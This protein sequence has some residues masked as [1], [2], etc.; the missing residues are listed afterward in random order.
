[1]RRVIF[2]FLTTTLFF[3]GLT[4]LLRAQAIVK[5]EVVDTDTGQPLQGAHVFLSGT[6]LG[7]YSDRSGQYTL[8]RIPIGSFR[9]IVTMIGY[10]RM[11]YNVDVEPGDQLTIDLNLKP[12][13][14]EMDEI[15]VDDLGKKWRRN[16][17]RFEELFLGMSE[18]ADSVFILNPD[19]LRFDT[20]FWGRLKAEALAPLEIVNKSLGYEITYYLFEFKHTGH[21]TYWDGEPLFKEMTPSDPTQKFLWEFNRLK[22]FHGSMRHFWLS[23]LEDRVEEEGFHMYRVWEPMFPGDTNNLFKVTAEDIVRPAEKEYLKEVR[24]SGSL[25]IV[26][27]REEEDWRY[28]EWTNERNRGPGW[29]QVS[30]LELNERSITVD[31]SGEVVEPYGA[32]QQGYL[33]FHRLADLTPREYRPDGYFKATNR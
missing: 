17:A 24:F 2:I 18:N 8:R 22:A 31:P 5:G 15:N 3:F 1:M 6:K 29:S 14:Y 9:I 23:V 12:V 16:L 10:E 21:T 26:Y 32:I 11:V 13:V 27:M 28:L 4:D 19:V 33:G 20:N 30:W 7:T 25:E